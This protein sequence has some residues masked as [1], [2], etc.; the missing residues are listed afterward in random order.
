[1]LTLHTTARTISRRKALD[2][3]LAQSPTWGQGTEEGKFKASQSPTNAAQQ[4]SVTLSA[5]SVKI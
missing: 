2:T 1:M 5:S 3:P 4:S